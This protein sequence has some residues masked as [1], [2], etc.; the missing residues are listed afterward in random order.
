[1]SQSPPSNGQFNANGDRWA[2]MSFGPWKY[3]VSVTAAGLV[4]LAC[5]WQLWTTREDTLAAAR[6]CREHSRDLLQRLD[7]LIDRLERQK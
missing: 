7:R 5:G 4:F 6:E 2:S 1:M 3:L